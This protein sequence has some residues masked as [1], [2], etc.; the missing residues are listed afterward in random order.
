MH[1]DHTC[2]ATPSHPIFQSLY[3]HCPPPCPPS[4]RSL[5]RHLPPI[6]SLPALFLATFLTL[7]LFVPTPLNLNYPSCSPPSCIHFP[8]MHARI[9]HP[10][11]PFTP[12]SY[13]FFNFLM[14]ISMHTRITHLL[15]PQAYDAFSLSKLI[16]A[17][18]ILPIPVL[19]YPFFV[20]TLHSTLKSF[21]FSAPSAADQGCNLKAKW[22]KGISSQ[23]SCGRKPA[24]SS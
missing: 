5:A 4:I 2:M 21:A 16:H 14:P 7:S 22:F 23:A 11:L 3:T 24:G 8:R 19:Q 1:M 12:T 15:Y 20:L 13:S 9:V 17:Y 10:W 6:P 18:F